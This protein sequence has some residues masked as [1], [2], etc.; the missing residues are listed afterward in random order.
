[1]RDTGHIVPSGL[2][3]RLSGSSAEYY[4]W[5]IKAGSQSHVI[6]TLC[7]IKWWVLFSAWVHYLQYQQLILR[8]MIVPSPH[9]TINGGAKISDCATPL[10]IVHQFSVFSVILPWKKVRIHP[11]GLVLKMA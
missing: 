7:L 4:Q 5:M 3:E 1:M 11:G 9:L 8:V 6:L 10:A 2:D